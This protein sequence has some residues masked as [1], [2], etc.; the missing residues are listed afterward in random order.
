VRSVRT[1]FAAPAFFC[2]YGV[3][4]KLM[5]RKK[6]LVAAF[7]VYLQWMQVKRMLVKVVCSLQASLKFKQFLY[8]FEQETTY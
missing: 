8:Q 4:K 5:A 3:L 1:G 7:R 2:A 6:R